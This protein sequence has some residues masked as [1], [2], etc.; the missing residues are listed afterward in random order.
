MSNLAGPDKRSSWPYLAAA[1]VSLVGLGDAIYLTV[2]DLTGESLRCTIISGCS[3]VLS[4]K[5]AHIGSIPLAA[6]GAFAY[7]VFFSLAILAVFGYGFTRPLLLALVSVMFLTT[8]WL[9]Y[10]QAF[11]IRHFCQY[12]LLS[13]AVTIILILIIGLT[14]LKRLRTG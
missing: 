6:L 2:Q 13:A 11:V 3:E 8:L 14:S 1:L 5:Y 12:C 7:F 9:L 10:L 4:S